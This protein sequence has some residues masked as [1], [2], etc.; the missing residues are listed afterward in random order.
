MFTIM[1]NI[2]LSYSYN[3][4]LSLSYDSVAIFSAGTCST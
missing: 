4:G 2:L 1:A 3:K